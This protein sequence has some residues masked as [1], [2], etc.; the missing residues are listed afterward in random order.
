MIDFT[1]LVLDQYGILYTYADYDLAKNRTEQNTALYCIKGH[2]EPIVT[3]LLI[4][5]KKCRKPGVVILCKAACDWL[6]I[7]MN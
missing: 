4:G 6:I 5:T 7:K 1:K 3:G 2:S